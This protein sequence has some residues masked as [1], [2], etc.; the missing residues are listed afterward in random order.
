MTIQ[1]DHAVIAG[2]RAAQ[3]GNDRFENRAHSYR[4]YAARSVMISLG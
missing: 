1:N 4:Q 3:R 2:F